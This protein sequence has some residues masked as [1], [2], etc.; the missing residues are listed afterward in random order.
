M[1]KECDHKRIKKNF[2]HGKKSTPVMF[3][4]DCG[5]VIKP[6]DVMRDPKRQK[7][8]NKIPRKKG[9]KK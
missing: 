6:K 4:K 7:Q 8:I 5:K 1:N 9:K 2:P 3:C